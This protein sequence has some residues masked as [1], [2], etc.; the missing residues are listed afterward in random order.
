VARRPMRTGWR[1]LGGCLL[2]AGLAVAG[3]VVGEQA[4]FAA[5]APAGTWQPAARVELPPVIN[6]G[7][8][9]KVNSIACPSPG[10][11]T[12]VGH[13]TDSHDTVAAIAAS[14]VNH[15]WGAAIQPFGTVLTGYSKP[16]LLSVSCSSA[17]NCSAVGVITYSGGWTSG[18]L[19]NEDKGKWDHSVY[20]SPANQDAQLN[21]VSCPHKGDDACAAGGYYVDAS[22]D[23]QAL[24]LDEVDDGNWAAL[25][26]VPGLAA[27]NALGNAA[28]TSVSCPSAGNCAVGGYYTDAS[29]NRQAFVV[30]EKKGVWKNALE[31]AG[32]L[33]TGGYAQVN[34]V[35]CASAGNCVAAG[36]FF[37]YVAPTASTQAFEVTEKNGTWGKA[38]E[39][40]GTATLNAHGLALITSV[41]CAPSAGPLNCALGG[42]FQDKNGHAQALVDLLRNGVWQKASAIAVGH[43]IGGYAQVSTVSCPAA[44]DCAAG[45]YYLGAP[46]SS[47]KYEAFLVSLE[48]F[49]WKPVEEVPGTNVL[50]KGMTA[51]V[52]AVSCPS[53]GFC[54]AG[55]FFSDGHLGGTLPFTAD[56]AVTQATT[57][58]LG[59]S[60]A[61]VKY[62]HEQSEKIS[63]QVTPADS[64]PATGTVTIAVGKT[65]LCKVTLSAGKASCAL[66][67]KRLGPGGYHVTATYAGATYFAG[68]ASAAK[69]LKVTG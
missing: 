56:G 5:P 14:E 59:L 22:G 47:Q 26:G 63:V 60:A 18:L 51:R 10:N 1:V 61:T 7:Q 44:G 28:V 33:N 49:A 24:L 64:G 54:A 23:T 8:F 31:V 55:G 53:V 50:N 6:F 52:D 20:V 58:A 29:G 3:G 42:R 46:G 66:A 12:A 2:A 39:V 25:P 68:S 21:S 38:A 27:L 69:T 32:P 15:A 40:P 37:R 65:A 62:G 4:A 45:G 41:S 19:L 17:G 13:F 9:A 16:D 48:G 35:S 43:N 34:A 11:C 57:T 30:I 67:A 36:Q